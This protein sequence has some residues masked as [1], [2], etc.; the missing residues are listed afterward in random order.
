MG[1]ECSHE[2]S[3][4]TTKDTRAQTLLPTRIKPQIL[5]PQPKITK[6]PTLHV[7]ISQSKTAILESRCSGRTTRGSP[8]AIPGGAPRPLGIVLY[9]NFLTQRNS[10]PQVCWTSTSRNPSV[11]EESNSICGS[12]FRIP[13]NGI[14]SRGLP[15]QDLIKTTKEATTSLATGTQ[16]HQRFSRVRSE[17]QMEGP[18]VTARNLSSFTKKS[19]YS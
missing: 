12:L 19:E 7:R 15:I 6:L 5:P 18:R 2:M 3:L 4:V 13:K 1:D 11:E 17:A 10:P 9:C 16:I 14:G 8:P